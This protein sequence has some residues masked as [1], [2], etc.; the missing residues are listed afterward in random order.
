MRFTTTLFRPGAIL[1]AELGTS[2]EANRWQRVDPGDA[3]ALASSQGMLLR[4]P[5]ADKRVMGPLTITA[6][7]LTPNGDGINDEA[8]FE[9]SVLRLTG[10]R[11]VQT[12]LYDLGGGLVRTWEERRPPRERI[13]RSPLVRPRPER[14]AGATWDLPVGD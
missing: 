6:P 4:G 9:F 5:L 8:R 12:R 2:S 14:P 3:T 1:Q 10:Q 13:V 11:A 7:I